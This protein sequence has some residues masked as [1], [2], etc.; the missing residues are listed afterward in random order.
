MARACLVALVALLA[1][2]LVAPAG[3]ATK[4]D[5]SVLAVLATYGPMPYGTSEFQSVAAEAIAFY[6]ASS[7]N[8]MRLRFDVT[9]WLAAFGAAP[10]CGGVSNRSLD[11]VV[12]PARDAAV[13]AGYDVD[14]YDQ[15]MY[16]LAGSHCGFYGV[17]WGHQVMLTREPSVELLV[18]E[19]GHTLGLGHALSTVLSPSCVV[20]CGVMDPGDPYSPM[21]I[22]MLDFSVYEKTLLQWV[23]PQPHA[24]AAGTY[25]IG[26][27]SIA[28]KL[29]QSLVVDTAYGAWWIEYRTKPFR[30]LL[31]RFVDSDQNLTVF[32]PSAALVLRPSGARRNWVAVGET[33]RASGLFSVKL[34]RATGTQASVRLRWIGATRDLFA[35]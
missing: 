16:A 35:R 12:A 27:A 18:H 15:V 6:K 19:L 14:L 11:G 9:P 8:Q 26:S 20:R 2:V 32:A 31:V 33:F 5:N 22:G 21:G 4:G 23:G 29:P 13:H 3:S 24:R 1:A 30:G 7:F 34:T 25:A 17:T 10:S 28:T